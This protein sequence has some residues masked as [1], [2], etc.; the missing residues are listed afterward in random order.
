MSEPVTASGDAPVLEVR[1]VVKHFPVGRSMFASRRGLLRAVDGISFSLAAGQTLGVVGESGCGKSTLAKMTL[2]LETPTSGEVRLKGRPLGSVDRSW[3]STVIQLVMQDPYSSLNPRMTVYDIVAEAFVAHPD[4]APRSQRRALVVEM[5]GLV[6][7][8]P[9]QLNKFPRQLSGGQR[10]RVGI[11]R[12]LAPQ[13]SI[14]VCDEPVS[15]LDVSVQAQVIN[16]LGSLQ[17]SLGLA[18]VFIS[19]D[20]SVVRHVSD[21]IAVVYL[22]RIVEEGPAH[23]VYEQPAHPYTQA[24]LASVAA[25]EFAA[26]G[27]EIRKRARIRGELPDPLNPPSGCPFRSRCYKAQDICAEQAP[28][29]LPL[30]SDQHRARCHFP[31]IAVNAAGAAEGVAVR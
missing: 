20:L 8:G 6:G 4:L 13:P 9:Q 19:H 22:G 11:A 31:D 18:Y 17:A 21:R 25:A 12:A 1:D 30:E 15:A 28:E 2:G 27:T 24:L 16:L 23:T 5:L 29:L 7:L 3:R 26:D 10:Q 14:M